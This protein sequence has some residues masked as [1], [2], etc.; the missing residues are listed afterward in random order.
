MKKAKRPKNYKPEKS[1]PSPEKTTKY[2]EER[3]SLETVLQEL[4]CKIAKEWQTSLQ[5]AVPPSLLKIF[6]KN[7]F[8]KKHGAINLSYRYDFSEQVERAYIQIEK[9]SLSAFIKRARALV[10]YLKEKRQQ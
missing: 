1:K 9:T 8:M 2:Q 4:G 10:K 5:I 6:R 7:F 3:I